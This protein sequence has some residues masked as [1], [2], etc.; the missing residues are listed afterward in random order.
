MSCAGWGLRPQKV[1]VYNFLI[2]ADNGLL[3]RALN[4]FGEVKDVYNRCWL[5]LCGVAD[6]VRVVSLVSNQAILGI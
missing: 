6:R 5:H 2:E 3:V 4:K 1:F